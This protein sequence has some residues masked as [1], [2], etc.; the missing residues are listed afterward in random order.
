[1]DFSIREHLK[2]MGVEIDGPMDAFVQQMEAKGFSVIEK[3]VDSIVMKGTFTNKPVHLFIPLTSITK[4]VH[5]IC[6]FYEE[7]NSWYSIKSDY[8]NLK[9]AYKD[10]YSLDVENHSFLDPYYEGDGYEMQAVELGKCR[11]I[12]VFKTQYGSISLSI[13]QAKKIIVSY[14]D[15]INS[16]LAEQESNSAL[17]EEI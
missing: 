11:Y 8:N 4:K 2:F 9:N 16:E 1:M 13:T 12:S 7:N 10:K 3:H 17:Q 15:S 6:V 14:T 5:N